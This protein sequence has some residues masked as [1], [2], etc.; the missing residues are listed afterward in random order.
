M[1]LFYRWDEINKGTLGEFG[2]RVVEQHFK[3]EGIRFWKL[4]RDY[5]SLLG[6][7][8]VPTRVREVLE[9][10]RDSEVTVQMLG[11]EWSLSDILKDATLS[12]E[13]KERIKRNVPVKLVRGAPDYLIY[14][15]KKPEGRAWELVEVKF[16]HSKLSP[17]QERLLT[18]LSKSIPCTIYF[19][20]V[21]EEG[22][23]IGIIP[24]SQ[25]N[26]WMKKEEDEGAHEYGKNSGESE[27]G[28]LPEIAEVPG[29]TYDGKGE[30]SKP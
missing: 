2:E 3:D 22:I 12:D 29:E 24:H 8:N 4:S 1:K 9:L 30:K 5:A 16:G 13:E 26:T 6:D 14:D 19:V 17:A 20:T 10:L 11:R 18:E 15:G 28:N 27:F 7:P 25:H 23:N 21:S